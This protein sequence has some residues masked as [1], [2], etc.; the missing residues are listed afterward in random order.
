MLVHLIRYFLQDKFKYLPG[1]QCSSLKQEKQRA[2]LQIVALCFISQEDKS[3]HGQ[4]LSRF[5][6]KQT[7]R[8]AI[9][10]HSLILVPCEAQAM[11]N[12]LLLRYVCIYFRYT[13][14]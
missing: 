5:S 6:Q 13:N 2:D 8:E 10:K 3:V 12:V 11:D 4:T 14:V 9:Q 7:E 1:R